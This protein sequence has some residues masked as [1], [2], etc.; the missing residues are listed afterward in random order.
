MRN[1]RTT[2]V[3][4]W[5]LIFAACP[6]IGLGD[7]IVFPG[8]A[9]EVKEPHDLGLDPARLDAVAAALGSRGCAIKNGYVVKTWGAQDQRSD[10]FS[11]AKPVLSTLLM[12]A[13][14]EARSRASISRWPISAGSYRPRIVRC[15]YGIWPA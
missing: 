11:S 1:V 8:A 12:F 14:K 2:R 15:R 10:W 4:V 5:A 3:A 6:A 7:E 9:W 13:L